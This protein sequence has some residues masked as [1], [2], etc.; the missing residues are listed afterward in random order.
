M[1][2]R[3]AG[4]FWRCQITH[5][6]SAPVAAAAAAGPTAAAAAAAMV[7]LAAAGRGSEVGS[8]W[9]LLSWRRRRR[10]RTLTSRCPRT[11]CGARLC[12]SL[13]QQHR[14]RLGTTPLSMPQSWCGACVNRHD[15]LSYHLVLSS[16]AVPAGRSGASVSGAAA[17]DGG[18]AAIPAGCA[19]A[20]CLAADL[21]G[22]DPAAGTVVESPLD[23][24]T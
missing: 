9:V 22:G 23:T 5:Q 11:W 16:E 14:S 1:G 3:P 6:R 15:M 21:P 19:A 12:C 10:R 24:H 2:P 20:V 13:L 8:C 18:C 7:A 17:A 4:G